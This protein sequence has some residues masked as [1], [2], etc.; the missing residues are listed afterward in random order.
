MKCKTIIDSLTIFHVWNWDVVF[1]RFFGKNGY[2]IIWSEIISD[3]QQYI[4]S[5]YS[6]YVYCICIHCKSTLFNCKIIN[7]VVVTPPVNRNVVIVRI[8][9][10]EIA[11]F[12]HVIK[13]LIWNINVTGIFNLLC[14]NIDHGKVNKYVTGTTK[15]TR[16]V[17]G[18]GR[19]KAE[20]N[21]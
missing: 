3:L 15:F 16:V 5:I 18:C 10:M 2:Q 1:R 14:E 8:G 7:Y 6:N 21:F 20:G 13:N 4:Y 11:K 9:T 17:K 19:R 12:T